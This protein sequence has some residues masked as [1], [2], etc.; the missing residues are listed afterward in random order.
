MAAQIHP[1]HT[2]SGEGKALWGPGDMYTFLVT[3]EQTGGACFAMEALVPGGGGPPPHIHERE[4]ETLYILD[5]QCEVE[6]GEERLLA[7]AGDLVWMPK[8]TMHRFSNVGS[9]PMR[10]I[11]TF[12]PAGIEL[13]FQEV[14]EEVQDRAAP[15]PPVSTE[16]IDRLSAAAPK[17]GLEFVLPPAG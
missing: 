16:L 9:E 3:G 1:L 15:P 17:Y 7:S 5:G 2:R 4:D 6:I 12:V 10:M 8:R 14:F 11:L 13:F